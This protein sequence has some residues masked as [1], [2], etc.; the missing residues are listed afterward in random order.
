[1]G[2][3]II[4][5]EIAASS[6]TLSEMMK[7]EAVSTLPFLQSSSAST[8]WSTRETSAE[9]RR[10]LSVTDAIP[11]GVR[12]ISISSTML[13]T[14]KDR[15]RPCSQKNPTK[16]PNDT[17]SNQQ[18]GKKMRPLGQECALALKLRPR[19][20]LP[21]PTPTD[22]RTYT[23]AHTHTHTHPRLCCHGKFFSACFRRLQ[24]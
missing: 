23:P 18:E 11:T 21:T 13:P 4:P 9:R 24:S 20:C 5:V 16:T 3:K 2:C 12:N 6:Y 22:P 1:M 15:P 7:K 14:N 10:W 19:V 8:T 17:P